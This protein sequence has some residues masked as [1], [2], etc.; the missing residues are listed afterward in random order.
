M[1]DPRDLP[2]TWL[3]SVLLLA[4]AVRL[5]G[6]VWWQ[7]RLAGE[8]YF[9]DSQSYWVLAR[10]IAQ[11]DS[12]QYGSPD[13]KVFRTPGYPLVLAPLFAIYGDQPPILAARFV[14]AAWGT[15]SVA[16][17]YWI[18]RTLWDARVGIV[19]ALLAALYPGAIAMSVFVL[20]EALFS[21]L[22]LLQLATWIVAERATSRGRSVGWGLFSGALAGAATLARPSWL[23]FTPLAW[24]LTTVVSRQR[25]RQFLVGSAI[26]A[27]LVLAMLPWWV[28]NAHVTGRFVPTSLQLGVSLYD[29]WHPH[30]TGAS[31]LSFIPPIEQDERRHP[32]SNIDD[33]FEYRLDQRFRRDALQWAQANPGEVVRLAG[34]KLTRLWN[35]WPN[36]SDLRSLPYRLAVLVSFVPV[37]GLA[38]FGTWRCRMIG[39]PLLLLWLPAGY[40]TLLHV[41]FVSSLRYREPVVVSLLALTAAGL[42]GLVRGTTATS[43]P[44]IQGATRP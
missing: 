16:A 34:V 5:G 17:V 14:G 31:D 26:A 6:A 2:R 29:G 22:M 44:T 36:E 41:V 3:W 37:L 21:P 42:L 27:G 28:R 4:L 20:S 18:G 25:P 39:W 13:A 43:P 10:T 9:G 1:R 35:V 11:G 33:A 19:A 32:S 30:A 38:I 15:L 24:C 12:Y 7:S 23:L 8:F 40:I